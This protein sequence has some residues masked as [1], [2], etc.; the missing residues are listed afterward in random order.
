MAAM[1]SSGRLRS[2]K[3]EKMILEDNFFI[4]T[5]LPKSII[6]TLSQEKWMLTGPFSTTGTPAAH[7][8]IPREIPIEGEPP[9]IVSIVEQYG[10]WM[11]ETSFLNC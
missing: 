4:E 11:S 6:R 9:H 8:V 5:V 7:F 2:E 3:G 1:L 10:K